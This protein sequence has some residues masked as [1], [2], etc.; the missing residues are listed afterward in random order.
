MNKVKKYYFN[1]DNQPVTGVELTI[2]PDFG[3]LLELKKKMMKVKILIMNKLNHSI[4]SGAFYFE[5]G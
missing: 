3:I 1:E 5:G 4:H 2:P